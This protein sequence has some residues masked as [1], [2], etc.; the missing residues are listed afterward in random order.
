M[1]KQLS[2]DRRGEPRIRRNH[3]AAPPGRGNPP[4]GEAPPPPLQ[5][6]TSKSSGA[7]DSLKETDERQQRF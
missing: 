3:P 2:R 4:V 1:A 5:P 6:H 7:E